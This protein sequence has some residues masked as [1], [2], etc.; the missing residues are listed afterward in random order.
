M[1][2][3][4]PPRRP[5]FRLAALAAV[6][7][8]LAAAPSRADFVT[9]T[10][11]NVSPGEVVTINGNLTGWAGQYNFTNASGY[12]H[13]NY[14][15][16]CI[17]IGQD[18]YGNQTATWQVANLASAPNDGNNSPGMGTLRA[19]LI[20]ELWYN[21]YASALTSNSNAAAFELAI[22]EIINETNLSQLDVTKG[23][24]WAQDSDSATL[25]QANTW[26]SGLN[27]DG[28]GSKANLIALTNSQYQDYV[29]QAPV[30]APPGLVL[31]GVALASGA[32]ASG[33][34]RLRPPTRRTA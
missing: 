25:T 29:T 12:L 17:D 6:T 9:S 4:L 15:G 8:A 33:W 11:T 19:N 10:F 18:I 13:G 1:R 2:C 30:P 3:S 5:G 22:W 24:F 31:A 21:D 27:L 28:T 32:L 34:R 14:G 23:S 26:L 20:E 7:A 16:F